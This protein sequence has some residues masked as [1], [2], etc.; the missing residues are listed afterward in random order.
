MTKTVEHLHLPPASMGTERR[1]TVIRYGRA[2]TG[3]KAYLQAGLHADEP[4]GFLVMHHLIEAL[5]RVAATG[6]IRAEIVL[7]PVA[8]PIGLAQWRDEVL[9]G[10]FA[11]YDNIN[12]NRGYPDLTDPVADAVAGRLG[13]DAA[14]NVDLIRQAIAAALAAMSPATEA[15][16]LKQRLLSL[17]C[18]ADIVLDLHCDYQALVHV[19]TGPAL[20]PQAADLSAQLGAAVTLLA[21]ESGANPFDEA[22]SRI[23]W[24]LAARFP[25]RPIPPACMAATVEL[26]GTADLSHALAVR[27]AENILTFLQRR[28]V[29]DGPALAPLP[30][31]I[32]PATPLAGVSHVRA[33]GPGAVVF[34][35]APGDRVKSGDPVA[36]IV[37]PLAKRP[38]DRTVP[39]CAEIDGLLFARIADRNA[40]PGRIIAKIAGAAPIAGKGK[41]L[42]TA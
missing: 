17:S 33:T 7:V 26:R 19:Y 11:F 16:A 12:F 29:I 20:W 30:A 25:D 32:N 10:R 37:N 21:A 24:D 35:A 42:L 41:H 40:H 23:W 34:A 5:D 3:P 31:L 14:A 1:L 27:D 2:G 8:N 39:V 22:C 4:P 18:D 9:Q 6:K 13:A 28:G 38:Q 36:E 15:E